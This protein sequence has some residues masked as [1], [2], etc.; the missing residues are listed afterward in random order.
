[1]PHPQP[2]PQPA[3]N[4]GDYVQQIPYQPTPAPMPD[5]NAAKLRQRRMRLIG[6]AVVV[7]ALI[8]A[9][10][11][12]LLPGGGGNSA[13]S[14]VT[15]RPADLTSC[16]IK[17]PAGAGRMPTVGDSQ[18]PQQTVGTADEYAA[19]VVTN[20]PGVGGETQGLLGQDGLQTIAHNDWSAVDGDDVDLIVLAFATEKGARSWYSTRA[21]EILAAYPGTDTPIPGD[22]ANAAHAA[23]K[24]DS[25]GDF[26][27][28]YTTVVNRM[29]LDVVYSS[30][31]QLST[32]D[33]RN[34]AGTELTSLRSAPAPTADPAPTAAGTQQVACGSGLQACLMAVPGDG[35]PWTTPTDT[36][37]VSSASLTSNQ[38]V[39]LFWQSES[40]SQRTQVLSDFTADGVNGI[41]HE[42]WTIDSG[43]EQA[44]LYL[45]QTATAAGATALDTSNFGQPQWGGGLTGLSFSIPNASGAQAW[46]TNKTDSSGFIDFAYTAKVGNVIVMGWFYFYGS[47]DGSTADSWAEPE[48]DRVQA[49]EQTAPMGLFSLSAPSLPTSTPSPCAGSGDCLIPLPSSATDTTSSSYQGSEN[50]TA[51]EFADRYETTASADVNTWLT[52]DG[53]VSAEH[54]SWTASN[55]ATAD[56]VLLRYGSPAQAEASTLLDYGVNA[57]NNRVCTDA[58]VADSWCLAAPVGTTD[59]LQKETVR[60][61]AWKGVYE[62]SVSVSTSDSADLTQAYTWAQQ[63]LDMLPAN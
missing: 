9:G 53:F 1:M 52:S 26:D 24:A 45:V 59:L 39:N 21:G 43:L 51:A 16:L 38:F 28:A 10:I 18:W 58:A 25:K 50:L 19:N 42:D 61:L 33:L 47:F 13:V 60:V 41:A 34:W 35:T 17:A 36:H 48:L 30:P 22:S 3:F 37:W 46:Y 44:D 49:S 32:A 8:G 54:R 27:A 56:A 4:Y 2:Q 7:L 5:P 14:A 31:N 57:P 6:A 62:V 20:V 23:V 11:Y 55:G 40:A 15:C 29:V 63:Q 12:V